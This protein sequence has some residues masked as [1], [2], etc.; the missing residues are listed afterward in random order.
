MPLTIEPERFD[1]L[2]GE[3]IDLIRTIRDTGVTVI[4]IEHVM[5]VVKDL[6]DRS[7]PAAVGTNALDEATSVAV[8]SSGLIYVG[9]ET[10]GDWSGENA[11]NTD[12]FVMQLEVN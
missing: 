8:A 1:E 10:S 12:G 6:A 7:Y 3:A 4:F 5:P 11:G 2:V 9:G